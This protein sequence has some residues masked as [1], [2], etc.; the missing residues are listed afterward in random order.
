MY[1]HLSVLVCIRESALSE[2]LMML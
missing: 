2:A 1:I